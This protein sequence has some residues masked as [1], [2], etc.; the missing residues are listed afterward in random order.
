[1]LVLFQRNQTDTW[2]MV[3]LGGVKGSAEAAI[4]IAKRIE[5]LLARWN[6]ALGSMRSDASARK[7]LERFP[8]RLVVSSAEVAAAANVS[9]RA[10]RNALSALH[11][12]GIIDQLTAPIRQLGARIVSDS[13]IPIDTRM[14]RLELRMGH[15]S[16]SNVTSVYISQQVSHTFMNEFRRWSY[17]R[18]IERRGPPIQPC[19]VR[20][21]PIIA[22]GRSRACSINSECQP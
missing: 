15:G 9:S 21:A 19:W 1:V 10:A 7:I 8:E 5:A 17:E 2:A 4:D 14:D 12:A 13:A 22:A 3:C 11:D 16:M 6:V 20:K 18:S